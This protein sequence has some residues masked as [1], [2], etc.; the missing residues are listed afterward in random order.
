MKQEDKLS[1]VRSLTQA[2]MS[3]VPFT[4]CI[5]DNFLPLELATRLSSEFPDFEDEVWFNYKNKIEDKKL[6]TDWRLSLI[7]I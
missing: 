7:H 5:I 3:H 6:L 2:N 4:H 1:V